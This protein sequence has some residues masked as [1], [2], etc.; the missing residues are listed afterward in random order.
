MNQSKTGWIPFLENDDYLLLIALVMRETGV[1]ASVR[2]KVTSG[3]RAYGF[4]AA[5]TARLIRFD[6]ERETKRFEVLSSMLMGSPENT[7]DTQEPE[8]W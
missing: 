4:D 7:N 8:I 5:C 2:H 1:P 3:V 6:N